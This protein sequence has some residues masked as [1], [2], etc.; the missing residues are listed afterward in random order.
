VIDTNILLDI[1]VFQDPHGAALKAHVLSGQ[2]LPVASDE[3]NAEFVDVLA[4]EKFGLSSEV[5]ASI[6]ADWRS[7]STLWD[8]NQIL[9]AP[10]RCKDKDDQKFLDLAYS[11]RPCLLVSKDKQV[12]RFAKRALREGVTIVPTSN[13]GV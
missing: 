3:T 11:T 1:Y 9:P 2:V 10:W 5:Q 13:L 12:L 7:R 8:A 6:L 4:R